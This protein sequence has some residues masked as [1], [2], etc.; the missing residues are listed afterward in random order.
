MKTRTFLPIFPGFYET[1]FETDEEYIIEWTNEERK[2]QGFKELKFENFTFDYTKY[3]NDAAKYCCDFIE[4]ELKPFVNS[5]K[6][7]CVNSR[8]EYNFYND[9]IHCIIDVNV[10]ACKKYIKN[11]F[12]E[13]EKYI[14]ERY[15]S[16][17]GFHSFYPN[18]VNEWMKD[19]PFSH[20]H[21]CGSILQFIAE[22][23]LGENAEMD[24]YES[25][26]GNICLDYEINE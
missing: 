23:E 14:K 18:N 24:M 8:E 12:T 26:L 20:P 22:N 7:E 1:I 3:Y 9:S 15:N 17:S 10:N 13:F 19:S 5:V 6:F 11:N 16:C 4:R 2:M 25:Y 21:K